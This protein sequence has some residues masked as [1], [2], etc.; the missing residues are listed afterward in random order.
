M[1]IFL[2]FYGCGVKR[3]EVLE[4][5][6]KVC[7]QKL[8]YTEITTSKVVIFF[9]RHKCNLQINCDD[10]IMNIFPFIVDFGQ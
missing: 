5:H 9:L 6:N 10:N 3:K 7:S 8:A 4:I 1:Y 2:G